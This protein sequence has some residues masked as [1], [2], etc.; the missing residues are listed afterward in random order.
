MEK[1]GKSVKDSAGNQAS[2]GVQH[3]EFS[4]V[5]HNFVKQMLLGLKAQSAADE[6]IAS[7]KRGEKPIIAVEN[8]MGSFLAEYAES[9]NIAQGDITYGLKVLDLLRGSGARQAC[10]WHCLLCTASHHSRLGRWT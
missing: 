5:V 10:R 1:Q 3:T 4:S 9:N 6:A 2:A 8:T 7:L